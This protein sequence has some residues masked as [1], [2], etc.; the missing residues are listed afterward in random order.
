MQQL[1]ASGV[2][3]RVD[4]EEEKLVLR[5][6]PFQIPNH[7]Q[8]KILLLCL[9]DTNIELLNY[10]ENYQ[11]PIFS[12]SLPRQHP[13]LLPHPPLPTLNHHHLLPHRPHFSPRFSLLPPQI[14]TLLLHPHPNTNSN[15]I[16]Y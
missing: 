11:P 1:C 14:H 15:M 12:L 7:L 10:K 6:L 16:F 8:E 2:L 4:E 13:P 9:E 3:E 5:N